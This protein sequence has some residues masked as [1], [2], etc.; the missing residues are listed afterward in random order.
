MKKIYFLLLVFLISFTYSP[1]TLAQSDDDS[2]LESETDEAFDEELSDEDE[3]DFETDDFVETGDGFEET[4]D[5]AENQINEKSEDEISSQDKQELNSTANE[6]EN[7]FDDKN[8]PASNEVMFQPAT[9]Y[10]A[11]DENKYE[12]GLFAHYGNQFANATSDFAISSTTSL[13]QEYDDMGVDIIK[14]MKD[15][16]WQF[17][18]RFQI[19]SETIEDTTN[20]TEYSLN[21]I[22]G[23]VGYRFIDD[24]ISISGTL[25]LVLPMSGEVKVSTLTGSTSNSEK[26]KYSLSYTAGLISIIKLKRFLIG[27]DG[28]LMFLNGRKLGSQDFDRNHGGYLRLMLGLAL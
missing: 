13:P 14:N 1:T 15:K 11:F 27:F 3:L 23:F 7:N 18:G 21:L 9:S 22:T 19:M 6:I 24:I 25:G 5:L 17:G 28:G 10:G 12:W 8:T 2:F 20:K 4:D 16:P 26:L